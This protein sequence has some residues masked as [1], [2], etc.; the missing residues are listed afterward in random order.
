MQEQFEALFQYK[1]LLFLEEL[2]SC[3][4]TP[5]VLYF[6]L[7]KCAGE[8]GRAPLCTGSW[9]PGSDWKRACCLLALFSTLTL[10]AQV[11]Q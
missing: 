7:P 8:Y 4:L 9:V 6:S 1:A 11:R 3:L 2:A 5:F 10:H